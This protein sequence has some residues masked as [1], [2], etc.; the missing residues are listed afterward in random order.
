MAISLRGSLLSALP[1]AVSP[2]RRSRD[3][4][5]RDQGP[6]TRVQESRAIR[7]MDVSHLG[8]IQLPGCHSVVR[9]PSSCHCACAPHPVQFCATILCAHLRATPTPSRP[10]SLSARCPAPNAPRS[11]WRL[12]LQPRPPKLPTP[13]QEREQSAVAHPLPTPDA[14]PAASR[15][16]TLQ[17]CLQRRLPPGPWTLPPG[18]WTLPEAYQP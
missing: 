9:V 16:S 13:I 2:L 14:I 12:R 4:T 18:P 10:I 1:S 3:Q 8:A 7:E 5:P 15:P 17:R 6:G 11:T